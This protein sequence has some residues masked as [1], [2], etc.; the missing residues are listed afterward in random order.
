MTRFRFC[1]TMIVAG[2]PAHRAVL[3]AQS[4]GDPK[5]WSI[6]EIH[7]PKLPFETTVDEGTYLSL[8]VSP[9][10]KTI[11][12]DLLG[13]LYTV[14]ITGGTATRITSGPA[15]DCQPRYAPDGMRIAFLSD[16][17]GA[18]QIWIAHPDGSDAR[19]LTDDPA[20]QYLS[21]SWTWDGRSILALRGDDSSGVG[22]PDL[23]LF[24][25]NGGSG[26]HLL[27]KTSAAGPVASPDGRYVYFVSGRL[28]WFGSGAGAGTLNRLDRRNGQSVPLTGGYG[29]VA[30]P[31]V[32]L[33][34]RWRSLT[35]EG[36]RFTW[37]IRAPP[38]GP[39][40]P[41]PQAAA[42]PRPWLPR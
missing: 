5:K 32:S 22:A 16:R 17:S 37:V 1:L 33:R 26:I 20:H 36:R 12:F 8:D 9:D 21:P 18:D 11:V 42:R 38:E 2:F 7:G 19:A 24:D 6:E 28:V 23:M 10:G 15:W 41:P 4:P 35:S 29:E 40:R 14:P 39:G 34:V 30:R 27:E 3:S 25:A 13:D 31:A